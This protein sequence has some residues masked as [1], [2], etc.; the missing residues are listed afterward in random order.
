MSK[1]CIDHRE[2]INFRINNL[3]EKTDLSVEDIVELI[4]S[5]SG[6]TLKNI[7]DIDEVKLYKILN[8]R[9]TPTFLEAA[10][11]AQAFNKSITIFF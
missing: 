5:R 8:C 4:K 2:F 6:C 10:V 7:V 9:Y 11:I 3:F 1:D